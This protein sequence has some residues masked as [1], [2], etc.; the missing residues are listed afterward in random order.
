MKLLSH[1]LIASKIEATPV[2]IT[3]YAACI[4]QLQKMTADTSADAALN[5]DSLQ[6][7]S[8]TLTTMTTNDSANIDSYPIEVTDRVQT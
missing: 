8:A 2:R 1:K 4:L 5:E 3:A 7:V 6:P